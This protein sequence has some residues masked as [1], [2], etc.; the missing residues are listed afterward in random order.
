LREESKASCII[1]F[2]DQANAVVMMRASK[3]E[4]ALAL[5]YLRSENG[6]DA[7]L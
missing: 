5:G 2:V 4:E 3:M 7:Y 1:V 6:I